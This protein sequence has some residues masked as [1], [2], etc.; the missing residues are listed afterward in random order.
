MVFQGHVR[1]G[2]K[3]Y[4]SVANFSATL[5]GQSVAAVG[6]VARSERQSAGVESDDAPKRIGG[7]HAIRPP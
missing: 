6:C 4:S 7:P 1:G 3:A 5:S 2:C